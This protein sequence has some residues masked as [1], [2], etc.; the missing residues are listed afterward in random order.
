MISFILLAFI[1]VLFIQKFR[2]E[3]SGPKPN[4]EWY[5]YSLYGKLTKDACDA[6]LFTQRKLP[7]VRGK[8]AFWC[9]GLYSVPVGTVNDFA[10]CDPL[11]LKKY[12]LIDKNT[13]LPTK[14]V[15]EETKNSGWDW[16]KLES[17]VTGNVVY[18]TR[19]LI[20]LLKNI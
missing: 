11:L 17:T 15:C 6:R 10:A 4:G 14:L 7:H 13:A 8:C 19:N 5:M 16:L 2:Q 12:R 1:I 18:V 20:T 9:E 3:E